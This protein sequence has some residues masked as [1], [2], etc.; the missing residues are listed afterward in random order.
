[1]ELQHYLQR[2]NDAIKIAIK[3]QPL[4]HDFGSL[5]DQA[6]FAYRQ[7]IVYESL[8]D[9]DKAIGELELARSIID[10][11]LEKVSQRKLKQEFLALFKDIYT[12]N[13]RL[14]LRVK[15]Q[16]TVSA[17]TLVETFR[18]RTLKTKSQAPISLSR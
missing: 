10:K 16:D 8:G 14:S 7:A 15:P 18:A 6:R 4:M 17:I 11:Q 9:Y 3:A 12:A 2:N 13:V 5:A 1:M